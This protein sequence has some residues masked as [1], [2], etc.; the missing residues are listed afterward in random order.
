M[1]AQLE[2]NANIILDKEPD[3]LTL[4]ADIASYIAAKGNNSKPED[5]LAEKPAGIKADMKTIRHDHLHMSAKLG[6][7]Y[8]PRFKQ[9]KRIRYYYEG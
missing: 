1:D 9:G 4:E 2:K 6:M 5:W 3:L 8:T 7:G